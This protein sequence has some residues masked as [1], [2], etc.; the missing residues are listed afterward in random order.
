MQVVKNPAHR[1]LLEMKL[2][3]RQMADKMVQDE[4]KIDL[5]GVKAM[6]SRATD[7]G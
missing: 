5:D 1:K 3:I 7:G 4:G 6:L 2:D